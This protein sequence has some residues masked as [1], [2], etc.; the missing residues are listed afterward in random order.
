MQIF[1]VFSI[2]NFYT[3]Q[4]S[5]KTHSTNAKMSTLLKENWF[6]NHSEMCTEA[7]LF[8]LFK[9]THCIENQKPSSF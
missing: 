8:Q 2:F 3:Y 4:Y 1:T 5:Y 9:K 6:Y 7:F